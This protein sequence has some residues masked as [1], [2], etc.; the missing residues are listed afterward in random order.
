MRKPAINDT[1]TGRCV[2]MGTRVTGRIVEEVPTDLI[3]GE[4]EPRYR[5][6]DLN[7][8]DAPDDWEPPASAIVFRL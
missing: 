5:L 2:T 4:S 8:V 3:S 6:S 1:I 7:Y